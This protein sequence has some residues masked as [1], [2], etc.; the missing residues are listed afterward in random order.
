MASICKELSSSSW[1][2]DRV[3]E[4]VVEVDELPE[5]VW[6]TLSSTSEGSIEPF[7][8]NVV[9]VKWDHKSVDG[10]MLML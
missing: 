2:A 9:K 3:D 1:F 7:T 6:L 10:P 8:L 4:F 5:L